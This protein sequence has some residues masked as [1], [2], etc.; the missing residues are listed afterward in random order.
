MW[1]VFPN[2]PCSSI[3]LQLLLLENRLEIEDLTV[4]KMKR[5][6]AGE[7]DRRPFLKEADQAA[8]FE[9]VHSSGRNFASDKCLSYPCRL[10]EDDCFITSWSLSGIRNPSE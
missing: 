3:G 1:P 8:L 4:A 6:S 2:F 7:W 5:C 9:E 10:T